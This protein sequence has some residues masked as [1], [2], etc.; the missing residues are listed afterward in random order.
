MRPDAQFVW[1]R[2]LQLASHAIQ[3]VMAEPSATQPSG[4]KEQQIAGAVETLAAARQAAAP[5]VAKAEPPQIEAAR[6]QLRELAG[7]NANAGIFQR[8]ENA[9]MDATAAVVS[10]MFDIARQFDRRET[11][12]P[13]AT[14]AP[15]NSSGSAQQSLSAA[16]QL[17]ELSTLERALQETTAKAKSDPD[18]RIADEQDALA[19]QI[20]KI[21]RER[22]PELGEDNAGDFNSRNKA[23]AAVR[24][25]QQRAAALPQQF[26]EARQARGRR[27]AGPRRRRG[28][29]TRAEGVR[30]GCG[31]N[32]RSRRRRS[33]KAHR[34]E[35]G[36]FYGLSV[37]AV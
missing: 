29:A 7:E 14:T 24:A 16:Q 35:F 34:S 26:A 17:D 33:R 18:G 4:P 22:S 8:N 5:G 12:Q 28:S 23:M 9:A 36:K 1:A 19:D 20:E 25:M 13:G 21:R 32:G 11:T 15:A 27:A 30:D 10:K 37:A 6:Q 31:R 2:D 3:R